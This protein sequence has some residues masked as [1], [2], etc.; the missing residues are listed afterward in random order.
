MLSELLTAALTAI[1][2]DVKAIFA[3]FDATGKLLKANLPTLT[4]SD[5]GLGNVDNTADA[6]KS[7]ASADRL[8]TPRRIELT[9]YVTGYTNFDGG[10]NARITT[11]VAS[12][13]TVLKAIMGSPSGSLNIKVAHGI[14]PANIKAVYAKVDTG[15]SYWAWQNQI[16]ASDPPSYAYFFTAHLTPSFVNLEAHSQATQI[17]G[18]PVTIFIETI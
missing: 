5:V 9:G 3:K 14:D 1:G 16:G 4:K 15:R 11:K 17:H 18:K 13:T 7:V 2:T 12:T 8:T 10:A 6:S